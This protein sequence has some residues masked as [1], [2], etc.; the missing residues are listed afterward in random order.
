MHEFILLLQ[1]GD[2]PQQALELFGLMVSHWHGRTVAT[3]PVHLVTALKPQTAVA[4]LPCT[5]PGL[6]QH[7]AWS[8]AVEGVVQRL[9]RL[10]PV[11]GSTIG[12]GGQNDTGTALHD[13]RLR[14]TE[15]SNLAAACLVAKR[16]QLAHDTWQHMPQILSCKHEPV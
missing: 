10:L 13:Q 11:Q 15:V 1:V 5:L 7:R 16:Q 12:Q 9:I 3:W 4:S 2:A 8:G 14:A 6:L